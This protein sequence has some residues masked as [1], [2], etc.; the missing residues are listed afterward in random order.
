MCGIAGVYHEY[1]P[2][3][4]WQHVVHDMVRRMVHRGP[5]DEGY[6]NDNNVSMG[7]R[8]LKVIDLETGA[9]PVCNETGNIQVIGNAEIYRYEAIREELK[10]K[11]HVFTSRSDVEV[12]AHL[13]EEY[14]LDFF[15]YIDGMFAIALWDS[16]RQR[17]IVARDRFGIKPLFYSIPSNR[18]CFAFS[19]ELSALLGMPGMSTELDPLGI[20][21]FFALSYI[22]QPHTAFR[23]IRKLPPGTYLCAEHGRIDCK[24][25]WDLPLPV[26]QLDQDEA[27]KAVDSAI[28]ASVCAMMR[29]DVPV[30][31]FLSGGLDSATVVYHMAQHAKQPI[32]TFSVRFN[33]RGFDEG[34]Q[35]SDIVKM[36]GTEHREI[37]CRPEDARL[38]ARLQSHFGEPF[39]DPSQIPTFIA[40]R[41]ARKDVVVALSGDG[42]DELFGGYLTYVASQLA[43]RTRLLPEF[44]RQIL[45]QL[46][47]RLPASSGHA[48]V[49]YKLQKFLR[50]CHLPSLARHAM[51][52]TIFSENQRRRLYT[53]EFSTLLGNAVNTP[54]FEEWEV[55]FQ[56]SAADRLRGYQYLDMKT[57]LTDNNL[58]KWDRMSMA[59]SLEVRVPL[60][61]LGVFNASVQVP[62]ELYVKHGRTKII[63]RRLMNN[64]LPKSVTGMGKK[65]FSIPIAA[66]FRK[67]LRS[68]VQEVLSRE[69]LESTGIV[70]PY[71][72][73]EIISSHMAGR[74]NYSRQIWNLI[75]FVHWHEQHLQC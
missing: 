73:Q 66:W 65:G 28:S 60:L 70:N 44:I 19:S 1:D 69:R 22:P 8:R 72:V 74:Y 3:G 31:A 52:R 15:D 56:Q 37:W 32:K 64:R 4:N 58:A 14:G 5:D 25:Y 9:Q 71:V 57:Y 47:N 36:L 51:W 48:G 2:A 17:L 67:D 7:I 26:A 30:G 39:A 54:L 59:N 45:F 24:S 40:S 29:S 46:A 42:G 43:D 61:D 75:S 55:L 23:N 35:V 49:E 10:G 27:L 13:Y 63:L 62:A 34:R 41:L 12:I 20:D 18:G 38:V 21:R 6:F 53:A 68:Y 33:E 16:D 11:G 50:G